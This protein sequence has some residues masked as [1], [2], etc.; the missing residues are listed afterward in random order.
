MSIHQPQFSLDELPEVIFGAEGEDENG[1]D[2]SSSDSG[3]SSTDDKGAAGSSS[4]GSQQQ[5]EHDDA[6]D[7]KVKGLKSAL[8]EERRANRARDKELKALRKEKADREL[9]EQSAVEQANTKAEKAAEK[10]AK[11]SAGL[12]KRDLNSSIERVA[13]DMGFIDP[14]DAIEGVDRSK[15]VYEQDEDDPSVITIDG[16]TVEKAVKDLAT[17][18]PHFLKTGTE[19]GEPS[20]SQFGAP[21]RKKKTTVETYKESYPSLR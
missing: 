8:E 17:K 19:D 14:S 2:D 11:L 10:A 6:D 7:P 1:Q 9:G 5:N 20:G 13:K 21:G 4:E 16:K 3:D 12:L 15:L 18:K